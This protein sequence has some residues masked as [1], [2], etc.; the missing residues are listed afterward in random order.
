[1]R[2]YNDLLGF[3]RII[4]IIFLIFILI[5]TSFTNTLVTLP[6]SLNTLITVLLF[7]LYLIITFSSSYNLKNFIEQIVFLV[8]AVFSYILTG[9]SVFSILLLSVNVLRNLQIKEI[10]RYYFY[11]R[12][13]VIVVIVLLSIMGI[14]DNNYV[15]ISK[16]GLYRVSRYAFGYAHPNQL[17][18]ALGS[19]LLAYYSMNYSR[20]LDYSSIITYSIVS[21]TIYQLTLSRAFLIISI[22]FIIFNFILNIKVVGHTKEVGIPILRYSELWIGLALFLSLLLPYFMTIQVGELRFILYKIND[23]LSSRLTFSAS[24][25]ENYPLSLFGTTFS[26][27]KL[28]LIYRKFAVDVG[29]INL[30]YSFGLVP[31]L[32]FIITTNIVCKKLFELNFYV[33]LLVFYLMLLW[34]SME[35][36]IVNCSV[37]FV[38]LLFGSI[39]FNQ[40][41]NKVEMI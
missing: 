5:S 7:L 10:L 34:A 19:L 41:S 24:V 17:A 22:L 37:D 18:Q 12:L 25:M 33:L 9:A 39:L 16:A 4:S 38:I 14:I 20:K 35:N 3:Q 31:F 32:A 2:E 1:M 6:K 21:I 23:L 8:I 30:L 36:I 40:K 15:V 26:F 11:I 13:L 28:G 29:Y 27:D